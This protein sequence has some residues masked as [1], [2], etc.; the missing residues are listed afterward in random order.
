MVLL[1]WSSLYNPYLQVGNAGPLNGAY[2]VELAKAKHKYI[3][4]RET[5]R[6]ELTAIVPLVNKAFPKSFGNRKSAVKAIAN[7]RWN[8]LNYNILTSLPRE[9]DVVDLTT[10]ASKSDAV[11]HILRLNIESGVGSYYI[12]RLI[13][14]EKKSK[15]R[16]NKFE[17]LKSKQQ[18]KQLKIEHIKK[19]TKVS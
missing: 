19:L 8:P 1:L 5:P 14:E 10:A 11:I 9:K 6:F 15:G 12:D 4:K 13:K 18:T 17:N 2:K 3:E 7:R 16:K